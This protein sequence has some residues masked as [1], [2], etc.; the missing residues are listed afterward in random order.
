MFNLDKDIGFIVL[1]PEFK[2]GGIRTTINTIK[3]NFDNPKF[4]CVIPGGSHD[5]D[6]NITKK[7]CPIIKGGDTIS[8]MINT[9]LKA[10]KRPWSLV[11]MSGNTVKYSPLLKYVRFTKAKTDILYRVVDKHWKWEEASIHGLL[12][13]QDAMKDVGE[14]PEDVDSLQECKLLWGA[15]AVEKGYK[16]KGLVGVKLL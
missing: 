8:S 13:H 1:C 4:T 6:T 3:S 10:S 16:F 2:F 14:F 12:I 11:V 5:E 9:G 7:I 15:K